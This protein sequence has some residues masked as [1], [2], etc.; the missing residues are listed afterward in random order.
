MACIS[1]RDVFGNVSDCEVTKEMSVMPDELYLQIYP[2]NI[3]SV[4]ELQEAFDYQFYL[5]YSFE[6][7]DALDYCFFETTDLNVGIF[8][9]HFEFMNTID[10]ERITSFRVE[11]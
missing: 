10:I 6:I 2:I 1:A 8:D 9:P 4:D 11:I 5:G 7:D 3:T